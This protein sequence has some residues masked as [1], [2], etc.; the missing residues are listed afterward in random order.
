MDRLKGL[1]VEEGEVRDDQRL[2]G[3]E[4][5]QDISKPSCLRSS[6]EVWLS[7]RYM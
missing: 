7:W 6:V 2:E 1:V 4:S 3:W 5:I